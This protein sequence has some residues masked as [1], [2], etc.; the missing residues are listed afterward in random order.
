M[1]LDM[2][3]E[4]DGNVVSETSTHGSLLCYARESVTYRPQI[5]GFVVCL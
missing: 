4:R 3:A 1:Y 5:R 2:C